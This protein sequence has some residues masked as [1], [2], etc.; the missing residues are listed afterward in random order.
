MRDL[1]EG[2]KQERNKRRN[3][4]SWRTCAHTSKPMRKEATA[5]LGIKITQVARKEG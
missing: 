4:Q 2:P 1:D 5:E 3:E